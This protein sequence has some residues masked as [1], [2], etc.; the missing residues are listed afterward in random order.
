LIATQPAFRLAGHFQPT[1]VSIAIH[2]HLEAVA[3]LIFGVTA[4]IGGH[5]GGHREKGLSKN[6]FGS[7]LNAVLAGPFLAPSAEPLRSL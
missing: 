4:K 5:I 3:T 1:L 2:R 7:I 6:P